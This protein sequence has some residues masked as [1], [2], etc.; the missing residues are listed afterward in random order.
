MSNEKDGTEVP[1]PPDA[2][3][4]SES[5]VTN[6]QAL[7]SIGATDDDEEVVTKIKPI[8]ELQTQVKE[9]PTQRRVDLP[10]RLPG[11]PAAVAEL[12]PEP[13]PQAPQGEEEGEEEIE[14][15]D[16]ADVETVD[17]DAVLEEVVDE[18]PA[19]AVPGALDVALADAQTLLAENAHLRLVALY[20][21][22][23]AA[24]ARGEPEKARIALYQHEIGELTESRAGDEGAAVKAY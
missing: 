14:T 20:D 5:D 1:P 17:D 6:V 9:P 12:S 8:D 23:L 21:K 10:P 7:P 4:H 3:D 15:M 13:E 24:L 22:E 11:V 16:D 2:I 18:P 19:P